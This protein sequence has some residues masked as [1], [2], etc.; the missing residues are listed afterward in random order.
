MNRYERIDNDQQR[1]L[2]LAAFC[3]TRTINP[4]YVI[5]ILLLLGVG[6]LNPR[7]LRSKWLLGILAP[8]RAS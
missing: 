3:G 4:I 8:R 5:M 7:F 2:D 1:P 6:Y